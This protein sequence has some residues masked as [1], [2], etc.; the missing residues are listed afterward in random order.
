[1]NDDEM[2]YWMILPFVLLLAALVP[3]IAVA[4]ICW[5]LDRAVRFLRGRL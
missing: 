4:W 5:G 3:V 2:E 1:V